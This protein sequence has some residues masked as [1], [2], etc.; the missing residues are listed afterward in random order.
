MHSGYVAM[1]ARSTKFADLPL[2]CS[3]CHHTFI[4]TA[5]EQMYFFERGF[6]N[7]PKRC[8]Q[9]LARRSSGK[10]NVRPET[11]TRCAKCGCSTT[12]PFVPCQGR[13]VLCRACFR[14]DRQPNASAQESV[15]A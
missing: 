14:M 3:N 7:P 11:H 6:Y 5:D 2:R 8:K 10:A 9:C 12:V 4:F 15:G 13:P 1:T